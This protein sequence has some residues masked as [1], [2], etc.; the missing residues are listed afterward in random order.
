MNINWDN[1]LGI[2]KEYGCRGLSC[3][4]KCLIAYPMHL[5]HWKIIMAWFSAQLISFQTFLCTIFWPVTIWT[6]NSI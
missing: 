1:S 6:H 3:N 5:R 2:I 4:L